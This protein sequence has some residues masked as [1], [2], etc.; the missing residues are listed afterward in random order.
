MR[1]RVGRATAGRWIASA[2]GGALALVASL[3]IGFALQE[4][5][6]EV[7]DATALPALMPADSVDLVFER[8]VFDYPNYGRRNPFSPLTGEDMGPRFEDLLLTGVL[9]SLDRNRS[10]ATIGERPAGSTQAVAR[11]YRL[12]EGDVVG[13]SRIIEIREGRVTVQ[14]EDFGQFELRTLELERAAPQ[15]VP[16]RAPQVPTPPA[17]PAD[18][19]A[20]AGGVSP[21][22]GT[23]VQGFRWDSPNGNG[24][25]S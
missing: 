11:H 12:R 5:S 15:P 23:S 7:S 18:A 20:E 4:A 10:V 3:E 22:P 8:E 1:G 2:F 16:G 14:V 24:G 25:W 9:V 21:A 17:A 13:N 6:D 19:D